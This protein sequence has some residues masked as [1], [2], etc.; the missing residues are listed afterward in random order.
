MLMVALALFPGDFPLCVIENVWW[1]RVPHG[2][3]GEDSK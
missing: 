3:E 1:R 2:K